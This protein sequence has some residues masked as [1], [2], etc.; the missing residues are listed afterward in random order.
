[1]RSRIDLVEGPHSPGRGHF[2]RGTPRRYDREYRGGTIGHLGDYVRAERRAGG[3]PSADQPYPGIRLRCSGLRTAYRAIGAECPRSARC[4]SRRAVGLRPHRDSDSEGGVLA[5][6]LAR[7]LSV[8][9][10]CAPECRSPIH[11]IRHSS[12]RRNRMCSRIPPRRHTVYRLRNRGG[13][14]PSTVRPQR[15][16]LPIAGQPW[17]TDDGRPG[18]RLGG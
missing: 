9:I 1:M 8:R 17:M 6:G 4:L 11:D 12:T 2:A 3:T 16:L 13:P 5:E 18:F 7:P 10:R 14:V 15:T